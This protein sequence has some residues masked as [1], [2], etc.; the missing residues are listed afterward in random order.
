LLAKRA[1]ELA[2]PGIV[3]YDALEEFLYVL[4]TI[5]EYEDMRYISGVVG[6]AEFDD[7]TIIRNPGKILNVKE[8]YKIGYLANG[9]TAL[10]KQFSSSY[11][12]ASYAGDSQSSMFGALLGVSSFGSSPLGALS[13]VIGVTAAAESL[14]L[15]GTE[16]AAAALALTAAGSITQ[17]PG[18]NIISDLV[19]DIGSQLATTTAITN[20]FGTPGGFGG[21]AGQIAQLS[22]VSS[23]L[24]STAT[25]TLNASTVIANQGIASAAPI[26]AS[27]MSLAKEIRSTSNFTN[28]LSSVTTIA[29][30]AGK[31]GDVNNQLAKVNTM[32]AGL[33]S[34]VGSISSALGAITGPGNISGPAALLQKVGGFATSG[35]LAKMV[36][37][38]QLPTS[39]ICRNP[40]MQ[41]P[42][43]AGRA[44]FGEGMTPRMSVDQMFCRRIA[45]FPTNPAGSGLM[46]FQMQ[47]FG[48][49][50][51]GMSITNMLSLATLGVAVAPTT[52]ALGT[53]I[54]AMAASVASIM[55][56]SPSSIVDARRSD[57]AI[58]FMIA[59]SSVMVNDT[60]CPFSTSVF[61][62]GWRH[63][64]SVGNDVQK[65]NPLFLATAVTSL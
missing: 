32:T 22:T 38:Q 58:P 53:Q 7:R 15:S 17:F 51:G 52:G 37:G 56:G 12:N 33:A 63:A 57:N 11:Y 45:T 43:Y 42:S 59:S 55:G 31:C 26:A 2:A 4:C 10:T 21:T 40:M 27:M 60:K 49:Y 29:A 8:L 50:G 61:S 36:L 28:Q 46:S 9:V 24:A 64:C 41:P 20:L 19:S 54:A 1:G 5:S 44:F 48:S 39:V 23:Q 65:Y 25:Q 47:N 34:S 18:I 16:A 14:G 30:T 3:P 6:I 62:S 13:N 35:L